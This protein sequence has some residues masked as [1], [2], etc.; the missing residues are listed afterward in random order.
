[1]LTEGAMRSPMERGG[2]AR[3]KSIYTRR[4]AELVLLVCK[5]WDTRTVRLYGKYKCA[6]DLKKK[7]IKNKGKIQNM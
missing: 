7:N 1:M 2:D 4:V 6:L 3:N 5:C